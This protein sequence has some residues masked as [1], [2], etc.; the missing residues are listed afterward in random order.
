MPDSS[1]SL[2]FLPILVGPPPF[3]SRTSRDVMQ[4]FQLGLPC[5]SPSVWAEDVGLDHVDQGAGLGLL[6][7]FLVLMFLR[8]GK[9]P[10]FRP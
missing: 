9:L 3:I 2:R 5:V 7:R 8:L 1:P 10:T 4:F 6:F